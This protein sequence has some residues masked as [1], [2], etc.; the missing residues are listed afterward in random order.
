[1]KAI[2]R[3]KVYTA[4]KERLFIMMPA[5]P[6]VAVNIPMLAARVETTS[7]GRLPTRT[8]SACDQTS[9]QL[10]RQLMSEHKE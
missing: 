6:R 1:M 8:T 4:R 10:R 9:N 2:Q 3:R 5:Q 7:S